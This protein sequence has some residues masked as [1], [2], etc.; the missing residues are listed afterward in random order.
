MT[1]NELL[2]RVGSLVPV[3]PVTP[4]PPAAEKRQITGVECDSRH[5]APGAVFVALKGEHADGATNH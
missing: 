5:V 2:E 1:L 3:E 4:I